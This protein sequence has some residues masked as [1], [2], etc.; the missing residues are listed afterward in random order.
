MKV[1]SSG[2]ETFLL[3]IE[4]DFALKP[5]F[6]NPGWQWDVDA[7]VEER[8]C[9]EACPFCICSNSALSGQEMLALLFLY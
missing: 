1:K 8:V 2:S 7:N 5:R 6:H 4:L 3:P 9:C